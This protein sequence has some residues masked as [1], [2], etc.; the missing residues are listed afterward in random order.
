M[1]DNY[2][3]MDAFAVEQKVKTKQTQE[4]KQALS[5]AH[6]HLADSRRKIES[7][8]RDLSASRDNEAA[9][10][11]LIDHNPAVFFSYRTEKGWPVVYVSDNIRQFGYTPTDFYSGRLAFADI[12]HPEDLQH[13]SDEVIRYSQLPAVDNFI[14][15]YRLLTAD[16]QVA[17]AE[18]HIWIIRDPQGD[19]IHYEG[20]LL[21]VTEQDSVQ[22]ALIESESNFHNL[23]EASLVGVYIIQGGDFKYVNPEFARI[24]GY[25]PEDVIGKIK[26]DDLVLPEDRALVQQN[27]KRRFSGEVESLHYEF[28]GLKRDGRPIHLEVFSSLTQ[29]N[30]EPA[31]IGTLLDITE[32]KQAEEEI[33]EHREHL[34]ELVQER[35]IALSVA[36]EQAEVANQSKSEFLANMSHEIR[37]PMNGVIGF[38]DML[39]ETRLDET[40]MD[41][42]E[43]VKRS[44]ATLL[45]LIND[46]LDFSK[47]EAG[48]M[49]MEVIDFDPEVVAFDVCDTIRPRVIEKPVELICQI[50]DELPPMI[51]GDPARFKQVLTNLAGNAAKFTLAGEIEISIA[52]E[53]TLPDRIKLHTVVRDTGVGIDPNKLADIFM[54]F[55]QADGSTTRKFGGTGLGLSICR[56]IAALMQGS[57]WA[58]SEAGQGSR[59]H[60]TAWFEKSKAECSSKG[61]SHYCVQAKKALIVDD[62]TTNLAI[63]RHHLTQLKMR[64]TSLDGGRKVTDVLLRAAKQG[65]PFDICI[66]DIQMP[67]VSGYE[68]AAAIR[69]GPDVI[70]QIPLLA[71]SSGHKQDA[72]RCESVGFNGFIS[73][74]V[75]RNKLYRMLQRLLGVEISPERQT[76]IVTQ[77]TVK[78]EM[79]RSA[80]ILL[81]EDNPVNQKLAQ[82][83]LSKAGYQ[84]KTVE[85]GAIA[86]QIFTQTL[87]CFDLIFMD[88]QM[89]V[90]D[91]LTATQKIRQWEQEQTRSDENA[92]AHRIPIIA[93]TANA[94]N[95]DREKC[96]AAGMDDY[97]AKPIKRDGVFQ[98]VSRWVMDEAGNMG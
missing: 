28:R 36:K 55:K 45:S 87:E 3:N 10:K 78:E 85:N 86:V 26:P 60:F 39:L 91:G 70:K 44:G 18:D 29:F 9:L 17:W 32:R 11:R 75:L 15:K 47:I 58:E 40:Q 84:I 57:V 13:V 82:I 79:K 67:E 59:F 76:A 94:L 96:L 5:Q 38:T 14:R 77:H 83:M 89:P 52:V 4:L 20:A 98:M 97:I 65:D 6:A 93:M 56:K 19:I 71:L 16:K 73:K 62:N 30:A 66:S 54:P 49:E 64:V 61:F 12:I 8:E 35:T 51:K 27:L 2:N 48:K 21:D 37:T 22:H 53:E 74:P 7:L 72:K 42:V 90:M 92:T 68:L 41:Y 69:H 50:D 80:R 1:K 95:G 31:V 43:A 46:I 63:L 24:L 25:E 88:V 23:T 81:V 33:R 34:E